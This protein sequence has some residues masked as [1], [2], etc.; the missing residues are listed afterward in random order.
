MTS[1]ASKA[2]I[3]LGAILIALE[4]VLYV[5]FSQFGLDDHLCKYPKSSEPSTGARVFNGVPVSPNDYKWAA[6]V[7]VDRVEKEIRKYRFLYRIYG[8]HIMD[9]L[10]TSP[11]FQDTSNTN[12]QHPV[13]R[14]ICFPAFHIF[15]ILLINRNLQIIIGNYH[16]AINWKSIE[17]S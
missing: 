10:L 11:F 3:F 6:S 7:F 1:G 2:I 9:E 15:I 8:I 5:K 13:S 4:A 17:I 16:R 14:C 12:A